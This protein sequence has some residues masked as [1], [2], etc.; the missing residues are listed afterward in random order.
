MEEDMENK[1]SKVDYKKLQK[2]LYQPKRKPSI[3]RVPEMIFIMVDGKGDPNTNKEYKDAIEMLYGLSFGIKMSKMKGK[4]PKGY[5]EYVVPPLEGLWRVEGCQFDGKNVTDK[6]QFSWTAMI[7]QPEFVTEEVLAAAKRELSHKKP[8]LDLSKARLV[9][10]EEGLCCQV[11]H[12]GPYDDE[13]ETIEKME[14][15]LKLEG[16][17]SDFTD[18]RQHHEIYL[19]DP[20]RTAPERLRTVIRHPVK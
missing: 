15:F 10:W 16:Y 6:S 17:Q 14:K 12:I 18:V 1:G 8:G 20:R 5:F 9:S 13:P 7:R 19:G 3:I 2:E 4:Q 11:M